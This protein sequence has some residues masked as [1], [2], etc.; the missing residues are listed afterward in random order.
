MG[1]K[2]GAI[3]S[4]SAQPLPLHRTDLPGSPGSYPGLCRPV[5]M[6]SPAHS[7]CRE[8][9]CSMVPTPACALLSLLGGRIWEILCLKNPLDSLVLQ[10]APHFSI[11][12]VL[13]GQSAHILSVPL[14][15]CLSL[16]VSLG[17]CLSLSQSL[18]VSLSLSSQRQYV[19]TI[20]PLAEGPSSNFKQNCNTCNQITW[21]SRWP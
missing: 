19:K 21:L 16:C 13:T 11:Y 20:C 1:Q 12:H 18:S 15:L 7:I 9:P 2:S 3:S 14:R 4:P 6:G 17:L 5:L 10:K 8:A